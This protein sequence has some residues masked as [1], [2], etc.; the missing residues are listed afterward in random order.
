VLTLG[1]PR[2]RRFACS[3]GV[4]GLVL[5]LNSCAAPQPVA[6][7]KLM[8]QRAE[9]RPDWLKELNVSEAK[10]RRIAGITRRV[11]R[12]F[13]PYDLARII[14][15]Q[16]VLAQIRQGVLK[17][18]QLLG[19]AEQ[20]LREFDRGLPV[21]L[22]GLNELHAVLDQGERAR[23]V[24]LFAGARDKTPEEREKERQERIQRILDLS[25]GQRAELFPALLALALR[26]WGLVREVERGVSEAKQRF[27]SDEFDARTLSLVLSRRP[28]DIL[29]AVYEALEITLP[30]LT[31]AQ[32]Q[33]LAA[34]LES[35]L[36]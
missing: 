26:H 20:M 12:A 4:I 30:V 19:P 28:M 9:P 18:E 24:E 22:V 1:R 25:S 15:L 23:L 16:E 36:R 3:V 33:T 5:E 35:R 8:A 10:A 27:L 6:P 17:R 21:L 32:R 2:L 29:D 11:R 34:Y 13:V 14:L 31:L 7:E